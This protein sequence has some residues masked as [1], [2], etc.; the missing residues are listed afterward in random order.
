MASVT[1]KQEASAKKDNKNKTVD[2]ILFEEKKL[3]KKAD[4]EMKNLIQGGNKVMGSD[5]A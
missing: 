5:Y 4:N 3:A 1:D 2:D